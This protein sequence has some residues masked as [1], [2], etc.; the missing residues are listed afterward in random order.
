MKCY[1][2]GINEAQSDGLCDACRQAVDDTAVPDQNASD[3]D[4]ASINTVTTESGSDV[5]L[6]KKKSHKILIVVLIIIAAFMIIGVLIILLMGNALNNIFN[7]L[8]NSGNETSIVESQDASKEDLAERFA[9]D[10]IIDTYWLNSEKTAGLALSQL[11]MSMSVGED[12]TVVSEGKMDQYSI[13]FFSVED[14]EDL[15]VTL[16]SFGNGVI[17]TM[18]GSIYKYKVDGDKITITIDDVEYD[19]RKASE[20]SF[21]SAYSDLWFRSLNDEINN[22]SNQDGDDQSSQFSDF[23]DDGILGYY[24]ISED[25]NV[26]FS[27]VQGKADTKDESGKVIGTHPTNDYMVSFSSKSGS[28][29]EYTVTSFGNGIV[30][31]YG[32]KIFKYDIIGN[33]MTLTFDGNEYILYSSKM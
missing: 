7:D 2:C 33:K 9:D 11:K 22:M 28:S 10:E 25:Q 20:S 29:S 21:V 30:E 24:W 17:K 8:E 19:L 31:T 16:E 14:D 12:D 26:R 18:S 3:S 13:D 23:V 4:T 5:S 32:G 27:L 15:H 6:S 1:K